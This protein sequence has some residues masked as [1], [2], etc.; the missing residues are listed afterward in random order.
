MRKQ[1]FSIPYTYEI[2]V[3]KLLETNIPIRKHGCF[4]FFLQ[5]LN[6]EENNTKI[7]I[8]IYF[9]YANTHIMNED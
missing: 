8:H 7:K 4:F 5:S 2:K 9:F 6:K 1:I 3:Y